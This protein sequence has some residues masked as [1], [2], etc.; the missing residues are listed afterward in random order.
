MYSADV[1]KKYEELIKEATE[2]LASLFNVEM[3][4]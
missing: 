1:R 2:K 4:K 3:P